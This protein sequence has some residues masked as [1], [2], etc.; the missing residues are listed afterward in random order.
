MI[1]KTREDVPSIRNSMVNVTKTGPIEKPRLSQRLGSR[2]GLLTKKSTMNNMLPKRESTRESGKLLRGQM[3][4]GDRPV[5]NKVEEEPTAATDY[6][7]GRDPEEKHVRSVLWLNC[8]RRQ[9]ALFHCTLFNLVHVLSMYIVYSL[10]NVLSMYIVYSCSCFIN[11][12]CFLLFMFYH[13]TLFTIYLI[14]FMFY[15]RTLF[16]LLFLFYQTT[17]F[18]LVHVL[19]SYNVYSCHRLDNYHKIYSVKFW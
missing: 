13:C 11:I 19:S 16:T 3:G 5:P 7:D 17:L 12:H 4:G 6:T 10:V 14:L 8:L 9:F 2:G 1:A 15:Q 18:T